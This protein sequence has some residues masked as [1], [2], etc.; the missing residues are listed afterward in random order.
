MPKPERA[1]VA[2][3][4]PRVYLPGT[5]CDEA[6]FDGMQP[7]PRSHRL[8][9]RDLRELDRWWDAQLAHLPVRFDCIGFSL[10]GIVAMD[11]L[12]RHPGR[13]RRLVLVS[14][15][16]DA[17]GPSQ[18]E[19]SARQLADWDRLGPR[20]LIEAQ[21]A[22]LQPTGHLDEAARQCL[23]DM[24]GRTPRASLEVQAALNARRPDGH[25]VL[26]SWPGPLCLLA[27]DA[28]PWCGPAVQARMLDSRPDASCHFLAGASHYTP[29]E[30][31]QALA[32]HLDRFLQD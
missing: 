27:G 19:R 13:V 8:H 31:P 26:S 4:C 32:F 3:A 29:L 21:L 7:P 11:L 28:D 20:G 30:C 1:S 9:Y 14:S 2:E 17:A 25:A 6:L 10:G 24:A 5:L 16:A 18:I 15:N 12:R 23:V 22:A